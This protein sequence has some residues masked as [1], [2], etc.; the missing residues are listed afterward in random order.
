VSDSPAET[1]LVETPAQLQAL[2]DPL[3]QRLLEQF[4]QGAT[5]KQAAARLGEPPTKLYHHVDR[6]LAAGLIRI[7]R[8]EK[9]R[10]VIERT[11]AVAARRFAVSP[12][13][14]GPAGGRAGARE[15]VARAAVEELLGGAADKPGAFRLLR[16]RIRLTEAGRERLEAEL[17]RLLHALDDPAAPAIDLVMLSARQG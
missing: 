11:F 3:R 15:R 6:L 8:E 12:S 16:T 2:S 7:V 4:A 17:T 9:R 5:V 1:F 10:S 13:A 14:F